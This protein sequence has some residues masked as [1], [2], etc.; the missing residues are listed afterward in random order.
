VPDHD[1]ADQQ[2][3]RTVQAL[4]AFAS[5]QNE[6]SRLFASDRQMHTT[7]AAALL[8]ILDAEH[9][10]RPLSPA[11]LAERI[12]LTTGATSALLNRLE[13]AGHVQRT[14]E[15]SDRR[16]VTLRT[17]PEI[18]AAAD[19]FYDPLT[20]QLG[21]V[22]DDY[23]DADLQLVEGLVTRLQTTMRSYMDSVGRTT[24]AE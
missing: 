16:V 17:T 4:R 9:E 20:V 11:R 23:T 12:A 7:D 2:R 1:E 21:A 3:D 13:E 22:L 15:Q 18:E 10:G 5:A 14:R 19:A 24:A 6:M 8:H